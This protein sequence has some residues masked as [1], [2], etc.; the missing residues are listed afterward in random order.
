MQRALSRL[1]QTSLIAAA[2]AVLASSGLA[3]VPDGLEIVGDVDQP[4]TITVADLAKL[5]RARVVTP[6]PDGEIVNDGVW[7][8]E[9]LRSVNVPD[10]GVLRGKS[11]T[12]YILAEA[13]DGY[14][15]VFSLAE[16]SEEFGD[17]RVLVADT[18]NGRPIP[19]EDGPMRL[20]TQELEGARAVRML[21]RLIVVQ[22]SK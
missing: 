20:I 17:N 18:E 14:Q 19:L 1:S 2:V 13:R 4:A 7:L 16:L 8:D 6:T 9:L 15:V 12:T 21:S 3:Q 10:G 22:L 5:P 11:L